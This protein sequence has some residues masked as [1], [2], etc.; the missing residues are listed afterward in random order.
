MDFTQTISIQSRSVTNWEMITPNIK[1]KISN[2]T[3]MYLYRIYI[4]EKLN[5]ILIYI[6]LYISLMYLIYISKRITTPQQLNL[7]E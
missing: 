5:N 7:K 3:I 1:E 4:Y 2:I 6:Y